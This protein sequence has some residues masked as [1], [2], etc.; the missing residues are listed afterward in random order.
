MFANFAWICA[1]RPTLELLFDPFTEQ[2]CSETRVPL[3]SS[4]ARYADRVVPESRVPRRVGVLTTAAWQ[5]RWWEGG[6]GLAGR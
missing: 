2:T 1:E 6:P 5:R 4:A 3:L